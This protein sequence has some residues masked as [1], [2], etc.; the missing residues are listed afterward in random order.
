MTDARPA[1]SPIA[2]LLAVAALTGC[3]Q[4]A[5]PP[6]P[7]PKVAW[8][9]AT[10]A[11]AAAI[12]YTGVVHARTESS[13]GF[14]VAGKVVERLVEP[15]D[16]VRQGQPLLKLDATDYVLGA[17][18]AHAAVEVALARQA[19][20]V[21]DER[22]LRALQASGAVSTQAYEQSKAAADTATA[23]LDAERARARQSDHQGDY[24]V[25]RAD[26]DGVIMDVA[27]QPGQVVAAGQTVVKLARHGA[28]EALVY[29][30]ESARRL[31]ATPASAMLYTEGTRSYPAALRELAAVADVQTRSY[32]ARYTLGGAAAS[33]PLGA[34]VT[35]RLADAA[36]AGIGVPVGALLDRGQGPAVWV[37]DGRDS[38]VSLRPVT[39]A[40]L[41]E[42]QARLS[43]GL[44]AG[45]RV[46][47][48]GAHL[49]K[50]GQKVRLLP[51]AGDGGQ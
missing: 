18:A 25:L 14:R 8:I 31:A 45:E 46:V 23:Q 12:S 30:P 1:I 50:A 13:L 20:A 49:L 44:K 5:A 36:P 7:A 34:T 33:A 43:D 19:Q 29:L 6:P 11:I 27:A 16:S 32:L 38:T 40:S 39:V 37:I 24:A 4:P 3:A 10:P 22:R 21:A 35:V 47:A 9:T 51:A 48:F 42:E 28:R 17:S 41:G 2:L 15:G 26:M